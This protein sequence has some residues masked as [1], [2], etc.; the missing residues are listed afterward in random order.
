MLT[1]P[2]PATP[3]RRQVATAHVTRALNNN[4]DR[5]TMFFHQGVPDDELWQR[6][7][8]AGR[9]RSFGG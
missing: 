6:C 7:K 8:P 9:W 4:L 1:T 5:G 3:G 2:V